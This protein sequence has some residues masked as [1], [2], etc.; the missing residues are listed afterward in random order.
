M[1]VLAGVY[2]LVFGASPG[3]RGRGLRTRSRAL[4]PRG[5]PRHG[6]A[7][8][9]HP[10]DPRPHRAA[11]VRSHGRDPRGRLPRR[12]SPPRPRLALGHDGCAADL[13]RHAG[14]LYA[15]RY[16]RDGPSCRAPAPP[17]WWRGSPTSM[18]YPGGLAFLGL[19]VAHAPRRAERAGLAPRRW[20]GHGLAAASLAAGG[21]VLGTPFAL[22]TPVAF[23]RGRA[24]RATR[25]PHGP[26]RKRGGRARL[27][28]PPRLLPA[29]GDGLA[30]LPP[31]AGGTR[32]GAGQARRARGGPPRVCRAVPPQLCQRNCSVRL[33]SAL[34]VSTSSSTTPRI[35]KREESARFAQI[36]W[37]VTTP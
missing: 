2:G 12:R 36:S 14:D 23:A 1:Y 18:K 9:R 22:L 34:G 17:G 10:R 6:A 26:V 31:G 27:P 35:G 24:R 15:L 28:V 30:A 33:C 25:G 29:G 37:T 13:P 8:H 7:R 32:V 20:P 4:L 5:P 3:R 19:V 16:W 11:R 21:F